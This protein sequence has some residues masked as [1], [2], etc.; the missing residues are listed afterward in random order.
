M[1]NSQTD[2]PNGDDTTGL[3]DLTGE[4]VGNH[5]E[6]FATNYTIGDVDRTYIYGIT[7]SLLG[8]IPASSEAFTQLAAAPAE[9]QL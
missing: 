8:T 6:L 2:N 7:D 9:F 4:V 1:P 5:V 3:Y